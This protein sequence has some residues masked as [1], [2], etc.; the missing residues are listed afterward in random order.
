M[1]QRYKHVRDKIDHSL[2]LTLLTGSIVGL[3]FTAILYVKKEDSLLAAMIAGQAGGFAFVWFRWSEHRRRRRHEAQRQQQTNETA[4]WWQNYLQ[5]E[6]DFRPL[7]SPG[8]LD[9]GFDDCRTLRRRTLGPLVLTSSKIVVFD[10][11]CSNRVILD[12]VFPAGEHRAWVLEDASVVEGRVWFLVVEFSSVVGATWKPISQIA[13]D[14][15]SVSLADADVVS[16]ADEYAAKCSETDF[17]KIYDAAAQTGRIDLDFGN[18]IYCSSGDGDGH[19]DIFLGSS[20]DGT[21]TSVVVGFADTEKFR[22]GGV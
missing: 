2:P 4:T 16:K 9:L 20:A 22:N 6:F 17:T 10:G 1:I 21:P 18:L 14:C 3:L 11:F 12:Q 8:I 13:V 5:Q 19:Y 7:F 15:G